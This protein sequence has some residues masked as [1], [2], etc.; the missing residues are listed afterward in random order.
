MQIQLNA[1]HFVLR[2]QEL[3]NDW[4]VWKCEFELCGKLFV[5]C[6]FVNLHPVKKHNFINPNF[7]MAPIKSMV[8]YFP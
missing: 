6:F 7:S 2:G 8:E 3:L 5:R 4:K 1:D